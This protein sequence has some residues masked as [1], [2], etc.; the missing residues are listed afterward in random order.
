MFIVKCSLKFSCSAAMPSVVS[1][2]F[3]MKA[4]P[5]EL[6]TEFAVDSTNYFDEAGDYHKK[7]LGHVDKIL[8]HLVWVIKK[9]GS[10]RTPATVYFLVCMFLLCVTII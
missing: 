6:H 5:Q 2:C 4:P 10:F 3:Y 1:R 9:P 8:F 7:S